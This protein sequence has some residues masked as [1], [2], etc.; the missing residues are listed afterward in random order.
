MSPDSHVFID[1][2]IV[3]GLAL[4]VPILLSRQKK[5]RL[6]IIVG[7]I[8]AGILIGQSGLH[9]VDVNDS[10]LIFL[11]EF[12]LIFL[13]FLSGI[14]ID[15]GTL[16]SK[17][18]RM[19]NT[20]DSKKVISSSVLGMLVF[21]VTI[22]LSIGLSFILKNILSIQ[23]PWMM[24]LILSTTSL[25][26]VVPV[27]KETNIINS[28][29]GQSILISAFI[30]DFAT[31]LLIT[32]YVSILRRGL[33]LEIFFVFFL[34]GA[35]FFLYR[36]GLF[37]NRIPKLQNLL[38]ELSH[39]TAQIKI[40]GAFALI[41]VFIVLSEI[42]GT[43]VILGAFLAG[44]IISLLKT[45]NDANIIQQLEAIGY[46]L[47]IPIF[48]IN[49][50]VN[51]NLGSLLQSPIAL[52]LFPILL[53]GAY[54]IKLISTLFFNLKFSFKNS[55]GAGFLMSSRLSLIIAASAIGLKLGLISEAVNTSIILVAIFTVTVSPVIFMRL[56]KSVLT[57]V[58]PPTVII[59]ANEL[60]L[61][62]ASQMRLH[63][64][65]VLL[66]DDIKD[67][68]ERAS[69]NNFNA[70]LI[71]YDKNKKE[72]SELLESTCVLICT[73]SDPNINYWICNLAKNDF[74]IERVISYVEKT[75][76]LDRYEQIGI[77]TMNAAIDRAVFLALI[78]RNP[79]MYSLLTRTDD[80]KELAEVSIMNPEFHN[81][82]LRNVVLPGDVLILALRRNSELIVPHG[83][84]EFLL[85]DYL[86][87]AGSLEFFE[88]TKLL[89]EQTK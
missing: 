89:L 39:A 60:G 55:I 41:L 12:G 70:R 17:P 34:F 59:G 62:V 50:G 45:S 74:N 5:I 10:I 23:S 20:K 11:A 33:S 2:L 63:H 18:P 82:K 8:L 9:I 46:G 38:N 16:L 72:F 42:L 24:A 31:M 80:N 48:F 21:V 87:I 26:V 76:E 29:F 6:P 30:A 71:D 53:V 15:F 1:L 77:E 13:M 40:R 81:K 51:I 54:L 69:L 27:L 73:I 47:L 61:Q 67:N 79:A 14:E 43:E 22:F 36:F 3:V 57:S 58:I 85:G 19:N 68:V 88:E 75:T 64:E 86:T 65:P 32:T 66:I 28:Q 37:M 49:I 52:A 78:A 56:T 4:V 44:V 35:F 84:T 7:E 25:G 83:D